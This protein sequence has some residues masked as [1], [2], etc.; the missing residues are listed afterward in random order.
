MSSDQAKGKQPQ[1]ETIETLEIEDN[2]AR[3]ERIQHLLEKLNTIPPAP[4]VSKESILNAT[5]ASQSGEGSGESLDE[6]LARVQ[7]FLPQIHASNAELATLA[8][9]DPRSVDIENVDGDEKVIQMKLG[10]GVFEDRTGK[11]RDPSSD[12][13]GSGMDEDSEED[14]VSEDSDE[15]S[16]G[17]DSTSTDESSSE[18]SNSGP[19]DEGRRRVAP[20]PKRA[21]LSRPV[22]PLPRRGPRPE[23]VVLSETTTEEI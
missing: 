13:E 14:E 1:R 22:K 20:L 12:E 6:L 21:I 23:I 18:D 7:A 17:S 3:I 5:R 16:T 19:K 8:A 15:D 11:N 10:L 4:G 2:E 9:M